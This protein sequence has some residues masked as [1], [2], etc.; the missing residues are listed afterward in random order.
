MGNGFINLPERVNRMN[1]FVFAHYFSWFANSAVSGRWSHWDWK[2]GGVEHSPDKMAGSSKRDIASVYCPLIGAYDSS[3]AETM[4]YHIEFA[5]ASLIDGFTV[6]WYGPDEGG[7]ERK[8]FVDVNFAKLLELSETLS[9]SASICYEEKI[10]TGA[11]VPKKV[12]GIIEKGKEHFRA[13]AEKYFKKKSYS[14]IDD[15]P[16]L[17]IWGNHSLTEEAWKEILSSIRSFNPAILYSYH[18]PNLGELMNSKKL[19]DGFYPWMNIKD[20]NG[21]EKDLEA[22]YRFAKNSISFGKTKFLCG[23]V[24]PGFDD[25]GVCGWGNG[26]RVIPDPMDQLYD[27]SWKVALNHNPD[28]VSIA[29]WNDWNE[30]S[31]IEPSVEFGF[32]RLEQTR[33]YIQKLKSLKDESYDFESAY[34]RLE[35]G[36]KG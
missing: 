28:I 31:V 24:W 33:K 21:Q 35:G 30:G 29:T 20:L 27:L 7:N 4:R 10:L 12:E 13:I 14:K 18:S 3:S 6:D 22:F 19:I 17:V 11:V 8:D 34:R 25:S 1:K 16:L 26:A 9:F 32:K 2:G 36:T 15:R 5:K 23:G